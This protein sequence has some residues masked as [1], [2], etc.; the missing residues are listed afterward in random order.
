MKI[1]LENYDFVLMFSLKTYILGT[2]EKRLEYQ[3]CMIWIKNKNIRYSPAN[4]SFSIKKKVGYKGVN[5]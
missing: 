4:P 3:Q 2:V 5:I 1:S